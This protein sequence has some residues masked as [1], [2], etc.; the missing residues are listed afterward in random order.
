ML[1]VFSHA[2]PQT[3]PEDAQ[4][5][6]TEEPKRPG[7]RLRAS[8]GPEGRS[9]ERDQR[10]RK[11]MLAAAASSN[12]KHI[13]RRD[14]EDGG[15]SEGR[16][17]EGGAQQDAKNVVRHG[18]SRAVGEGAGRGGRGGRGDAGRGESGVEKEMKSKMV[19]RAIK[20]LRQSGTRYS[21][22]V[23]RGASLADDLQAEAQAMAARVEDEQ[24]GGQSGGRQVESCLSLMGEG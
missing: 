16:E 1:A 21:R 13:R 3:G 6:P 4:K 5:R 20:R 17:R 9:D 2:R 23:R 24:E 8:G 7:A 11:R 18:R 10:K 12:R 15:V 14:A 22:A 19:R